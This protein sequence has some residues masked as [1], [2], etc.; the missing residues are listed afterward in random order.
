MKEFIKKIYGQ[1]EQ[2]SFHECVVNHRQGDEVPGFTT[3]IDSQIL[4][5]HFKY[6]D[7]FMFYNFIQDYERCSDGSFRHKIDGGDYTFKFLVNTYINQ[8]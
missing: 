8:R 1:W 6:E 7:L 4:P 5:E 2:E 3:W